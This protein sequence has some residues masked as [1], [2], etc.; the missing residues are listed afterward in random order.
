[1]SLEYYKVIAITKIRRGFHNHNSFLAS[2]IKSA[3]AAVYIPL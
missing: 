1:M 3:E 2:V